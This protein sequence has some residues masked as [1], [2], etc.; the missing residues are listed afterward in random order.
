MRISLILLIAI[1]IFACSPSSPSLHYELQDHLGVHHQIQAPD[2][3][4]FLLLFWTGNG[5]P[6]VQQS[7]PEAERIAKEYKDKGV[8]FYWVNANQGDLPEEVKTEAEEFEVEQRILLD[9]KQQLTAHFAVARTGE[10]IL[11]NEHSV[12]LYRGALDDRFDYGAQ[13]PVTHKYL[14][15]ALEKALKSGEASE[16]KDAKGCLIELLERQENKS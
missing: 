6:I 5:C 1:S 15:D 9:H 7:I 4:Q 10:V 16:Y 11:L 8:E 14:R 13:K 12:V 2:K 3:G